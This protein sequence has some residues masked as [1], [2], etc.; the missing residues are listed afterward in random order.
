MNQND[1]AQQLQKLI[2]NGQII[3]AIKLIRSASN[4]NLKDAKEM[5]ERIRS[6]VGPVQQERAQQREQGIE[7]TRYHEDTKQNVSYQSIHNHK[8]EKELPTE[9]FLL[10]Q[11]GETK[12]GIQ[13]LREI[14]GI[15][16]NQASAI[17]KQFYRENPQYQMESMKKDNGLAKYIPFLFFGFVAYK[18]L[19]S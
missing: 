8:I 5:V 18:I 4:L 12:Q 3:Q 7:P 14:K 6:Q 16:I 2:S 1:I 19:T 10:F 11:Q 17:A 13:R 15:T 9:V